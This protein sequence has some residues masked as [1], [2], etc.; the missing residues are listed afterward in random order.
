MQI[1]LTRRNDSS[2]VID[3]LCDGADV[4]NMAVACVYCDFSTQDEQSATGLL[5]ALLKQVVL[6]LEP[7]PGQVRKAFE[8]SRRGV[9]GRRLLLPD[10]LVM[11]SESLQCLRRV[12]ICIDALDEFPANRRPE[13]WESWQK[14]VMKC[15]K[16][17]LFLTSRLHIRDEVQKYFPSTAEML[18]IIS[19]TDDIGLYLR[20]RL[21]RDSELDA[22]NK[23]LEADILRIIPEV[24]SGTYVCSRGDGLE[25]LS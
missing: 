10:I 23:E 13:L 19:R 2:L 9:G 18:P 12:F 17:R 24:A 16:I 20:M 21:R 1:W 3:R 4:D 8:G 14:V 22:M 15:Q 7:I 25:R 6:A 11:F 5:G